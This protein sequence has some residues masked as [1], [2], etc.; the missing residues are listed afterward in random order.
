MHEIDS[1]KLEQCM[2]SLFGGSESDI[3]WSV[4]QMVKPKFTRTRYL[5]T[6]GMAIRDA[7]LG[8]TKPSDE[9]IKL[10][11]EVVLFNRLLKPV[12][13]HKSNWPKNPVVRDPFDRYRIGYRTS[14]LTHTEM[15]IW[16]IAL[17]LTKYVDK[18]NYKEVIEHLLFHEENL[19]P[20][21][22]FMEI[23]GVCRVYLSTEF[24]SVQNREV[25]VEASH[26]LTHSQRR[27]IMDYINTNNIPPDKIYVDDYSK[28]QCIKRQLRANFL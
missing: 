1:K 15:I 7:I 26:R 4:Q 3:G 5:S 17:Y 24:D 25:S 23:T 22:K 8:S 10:I 27:F 28:E 13:F 12:K 16:P 20:Y 9:V 11:D 21:V 2:I 19:T 18:S 14:K 6:N